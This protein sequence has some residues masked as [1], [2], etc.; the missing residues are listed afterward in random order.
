VT[1]RVTDDGTIV[2]QIYV[3]QSFLAGG[4]EAAFDPQANLPP[5]AIEQQTA[6]ATAR[7]KPDEPQIIGGHQAAA[8]HES[9]QTWTVVTGHVSK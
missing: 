9:S 5:K 3:E 4:E 6:Q 7:L 1:G 8:G 2:A